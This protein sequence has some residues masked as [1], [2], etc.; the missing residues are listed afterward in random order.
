[1][2]NV[3]LDKHKFF[4]GLMLS[5][6]KVLKNEGV[7]HAPPNKWV[8]MSTPSTTPPP[9]HGVFGTLLIIKVKIWIN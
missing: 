7:D 6:F 3:L 8:E 1:M 9:P 5:I 4:F 2:A